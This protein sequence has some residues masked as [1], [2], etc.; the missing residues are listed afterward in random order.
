MFVTGFSL[1]FNKNFNLNIKKN[2]HN[3]DCFRSV[4]KI[5]LQQNFK[6]KCLKVFPFR[7]RGKSK[8]EIFL[9]GYK[10]INNF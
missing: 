10:N 8:I 1:R 2:I 5:Y 7:L 9:F 4:I 6:L 3:I